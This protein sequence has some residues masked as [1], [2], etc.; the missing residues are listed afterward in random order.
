MKLSCKVTLTI[1]Q[2]TQYCT[3]FEFGFVNK[4][5]IINC[6][7]AFCCLTSDLHFIIQDRSPSPV[8]YHESETERE[9]RV[10]AK[11]NQIEDEIYELKFKDQVI[12]SPPEL[13]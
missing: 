3:I 2:S 4:D 1:F 8:H 12:Q 13:Y 7:Y 11:I 6:D 9:R 5:I 10:K